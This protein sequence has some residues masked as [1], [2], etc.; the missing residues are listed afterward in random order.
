[1]PLNGRNRRE[2]GGGQINKHLRGRA[3]Q[4]STSSVRTPR[5]GQHIL[6]TTLRSHCPLQPLVLIALMVVAYPSG[7]VAIKPPQRGKKLRPR[8]RDGGLGVHRER[9]REPEATYASSLGLLTVTIP[10]RAP[11]VGGENRREI[12]CLAKLSFDYL[13]S[14]GRNWMEFCCEKSLAMRRLC[15]S[16]TLG[17]FLWRPWTE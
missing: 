13:G 6:V 1:V 15:H 11:R 17:Q 12:Q 3:P 7:L 2:W 16:I 14:A 5:E 10:G 4:G 9:E 8:F